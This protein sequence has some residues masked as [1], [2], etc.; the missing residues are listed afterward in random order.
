MTLRQFP[1]IARE[2]W[3][4]IAVTLLIAIIAT[5]LG[6]VMLLLPV[7]A[8]LVLLIL[9]FRDPRRRVPSRPLAII[10]PVDGKILSVRPTD[11]GALEREAMLIEIKVDHFGA[12]TARS[13]TEGKAL[14][15]RDNLRDG[16]RLTGVSGLWLRTDEG[17][18]VVVLMIGKR[19]IAKPRSFV[20]YGERL[21]QGQRFAY[22]RLA[23]RAQVYMPLSVRLDVR[24]GD[25]VRAG[26][27]ALAH[28]SPDLD[29]EDI[30][31]EDETP[32]E[33]DEES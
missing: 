8:L 19:R 18:D 31:D 32:A 16:S 11:R 9:L 22:I 27:D 26:T 6:G 17:E 10:A 14:S 23:Q 15:L 28:F 33:E 29:D 13:P 30:D 3:P 21:G 7:L 1:L 12:Y 24:A 2:G 25:R 20:G 4:Y 5:R